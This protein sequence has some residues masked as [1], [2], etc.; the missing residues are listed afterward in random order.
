MSWDRGSDL[1]HEVIKTL[2]THVDDNDLRLSIYEEIANAFWEMDCDTLDECVESDPLF[3][4]ALEHIG[5]T[6]DV[7]ALGDEDELSADGVDWD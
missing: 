7:E 2:K 6:D 5:F 4:S 3:Q 1:M